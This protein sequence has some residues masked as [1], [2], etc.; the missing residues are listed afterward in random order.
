MAP[1]LIV[2][3]KKEAGSVLDSS[4]NSNLYFNEEGQK[5]ILTL[6]SVSIR[7]NNQRETIYGLA[8]SVFRSILPNKVS[9]EVT[10]AMFYQLLLIKGICL[11]IFANLSIHTYKCL[12][13][14]FHFEMQGLFENSFG[15]KFLTSYLELSTVMPP[16]SSPT[17]K[18]VASELLS[19]LEK[20]LSMDSNSQAI[21]GSLLLPFFTLRGIF[22]AIAASYPTDYS[23]AGFT[24]FNTKLHS[25]LELRIFTY[26][27]T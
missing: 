26:I 19:L 5:I 25:Y 18:E 16:G 23:A 8:T 13:C 7:A 6:I 14:T 3:F 9:W 15:V 27:H 20:L 12:S 11:K 10:D 21:S 24:T 22:A 17:P 4:N 2:L 1:R